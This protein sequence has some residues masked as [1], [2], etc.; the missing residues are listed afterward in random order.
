MEKPRQVELGGAEG[1]ERPGTAVVSVT[2]IGCRIVQPLDDSE[3]AASRV[4]QF[5]D[6]S[7]GGSHQWVSFRSM[8]ARTR[9]VIPGVVE[10]IPPGM[11]MAWRPSVTSSS[12]TIATR[13]SEQ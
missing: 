10:V 12:R 11:H 5:V 2:V 7:I 6:R 8:S 4:D 1:V 3:K 9:S 13:Q